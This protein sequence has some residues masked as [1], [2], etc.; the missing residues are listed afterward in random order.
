MPNEQPLCEATDTDGPLA[1]PQRR[2][3]V[4]VEQVDE[5]L[6]PVEDDVLASRPPH[7]PATPPAAIHLSAD[8]EARLDLAYQALVELGLRRRARLAKAPLQGEEE[9]GQR[10]IEERT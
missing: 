7:P 1:A 10:A 9:V 3:R 5:H 6:V 8:D 2:L 4:L